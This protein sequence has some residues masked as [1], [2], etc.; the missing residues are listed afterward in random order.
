LQ[1]EYDLRLRNDKEIEN[2]KRKTAA[3]ESQYDIE[4]IQL[5]SKLKGQPQQQGDGYDFEKDSIVREAGKVEPNIFPQEV[6]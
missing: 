1:L 3:L 2:E 5:A 4:K 6:K